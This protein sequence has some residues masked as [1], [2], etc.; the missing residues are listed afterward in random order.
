MNDVQR[1]IYDA[2]DL[3][4]TF[5]NSLCMILT[6]IF[7]LSNFI[8]SLIYIIIVVLFA[9]LILYFWRSQNPFNVY[10]VRAFTF[11]NLFFTFVALMIFFSLLSR[12]TTVPIGYNILL[13]P[14]IVYLIVSFKSPSLSTR[15]DKRAGAI[16]AYTG[17]TEAARN[18]FLSESLEERKQ[19][20]ELI[21]NLK[22]EHNFK[23]I[24]VLIVFLTLSSLT[25]LT[26]GFY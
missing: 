4:F 10:L 9:I 12:V 11:N 17:R 24:L 26:F 1:D 14:S 5:L 25:A 3:F 6:A 21:A 16:L 15:R 19:R 18:L 23:I 13:L 7:I 2:L 8:M 22:K 20:E